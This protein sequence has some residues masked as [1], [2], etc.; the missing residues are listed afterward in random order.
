MFLLESRLGERAK[1]FRTFGV[2][3]IWQFCRNCF[4][5]CPCQCSKYT[6]TFWQKFIDR[7]CFLSA[8]KKSLVFW[9]K[10]FSKVVK[11]SFHVSKESLEA[12]M[13]LTE[14][15]L[16]IIFEVWAENILMFVKIL[17]FKVRWNFPKYFFFVFENSYQ[18]CRNLNNNL[19]TF[20]AKSSPVCQNSILHLKPF[21]W[22]KNSLRNCKIVCFSYFK[23]KGITDLGRNV[24]DIS[25]YNDN[26]KFQ[27]VCSNKT[28]KDFCI[29]FQILKQKFSV[30]WHE[31]FSSRSELH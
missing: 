1:A 27:H 25:V 22:R 26:E 7:Y 19:R 14:I 24:F 11:I 29:N 13:F 21:S 2:T 20:R 30:F 28:I 23:Q 18:Y 12:A 9:Q 5:L 17:L 15:F 10:F 16:R 8:V 31:I 3:F 6:Y 4:F